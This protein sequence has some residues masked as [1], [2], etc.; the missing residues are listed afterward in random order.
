MP[1]PPVEAPSS[2]R[3][4]PI[5]APVIPGCFPGPLSGAPQDGATFTNQGSDF[6]N[7]PANSAYRVSFNGSAPQSVSVY[8]MDI[9]AGC[10]DP[11]VLQFVAPASGGYWDVAPGINLFPQC[12]R[13]PSL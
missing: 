6:V 8:Y 11:I 9:D 12:V 5:H 7:L 1:W 10:R 4:P 2:W 3:A 13:Q